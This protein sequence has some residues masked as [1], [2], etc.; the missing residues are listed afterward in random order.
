[1]ITSPYNFVPLSDKV[2]SPYWA[3]LVS[4]DIPFKDSESGVLDLTL[5]AESPIYVRNGVPKNVSDGEKNAF[6]NIDNNYFIPGSSIKGLLR[7]VMEIM[8][9]G[10]MGNKVNDHKYSVRDFQNNTIYPKSDLAKESLCGWL[11]KKDGKY[12]LE[13]CGKPGR[14]SH[15]ILDG[16]CRNGVLISEYY[17]RSENI[18]AQKKS[19]KSKYETFP[20]LKEG[21]DFDL[22]YTSV[23]RP[24]FKIVEKG[25]KGTIVFSGQASIR[26]EPEGQIP[27]GK[28]LEF[29]FFES[30]D[31]PFLLDESVIKNFF[32]A[33][34]D[35]EITQQKDDWKWRKPQLDKGDKIPVFFRENNDGS[36]KDM[37]LSLLYK[38]T[39]KNSIQDAINNQQK[40]SAALDLAETIFGYS[41]DKTSLKGRV[42]VGH[43]FA[44]NPVTPLSQI[45]EVLAGPK[46]SY[47]P[48]YIEQTNKNGI[49]NG[50]YSTFMNDK[51]NI[52]GWKR[53]PV[54]EGGI[55]TNAPHEIKGVVNANIGSTF[56]PLPPN[57]EFTFQIHYHNLRKEELGALISAIT[58]HNTEGL[59]HSL[60]SAK[61]LGYGK[62]TITITNLDEDKKIELLKLYEYYMDWALGNTTP[63]W[64][65]LPQIKELFS[66]AKP[67]ANDDQLKYMQLTD[68][69]N[70][71]GRRKTDPKFTL[72][73]YSVI[74]NNLVDIKALGT[75]NELNKASLN[76]D[77]EKALFEEQTN[78]EELKNGVIV[79]NETVFINAL[80]LKKKELLAKLNSRRDEI[81][82]MET[83][84]KEVQKK[85][86][87]HEKAASG[88]PS[89]WNDK[90]DFENLA[91][92]VPKWQNKLD[93]NIIS[94]VFKDDLASLIKEIITH[95][96]TVNKKKKDWAGSFEENKSYIKIAGWIDESRARILYEIFN[97]KN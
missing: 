20:F 87:S 65:Q 23:E 76:Y 70:A 79:K 49:L 58:F 92:R 16:L 14:I 53:Y 78:L 15:K 96:L 25:A 86:E 48:N 30:K 9:F 31:D 8:S 32:F 43:A 73:K 52:R 10:R 18:T 39:Y 50:D 36:I 6:N 91:K 4:H 71:K 66:M 27:S 60:G 61:P 28:H 59:F 24:V 46:A 62:S 29:V 1:M 88:L 44:K 69:V 12:Y 77:K 17:K 42:H 90:I 83:L 13:D 56:T 45:K 54:H 33:Y 82:E 21:Y 35:Q 74:A 11:F 7:S 37:G 3:N 67:G 93:K 80:D 85:L 84:E 75:K 41:D 22:E 34:Y 57:T 2:V 64:F 63:L 40:D 68:F 38:I 47:Y 81:I 5:K 89:E 55:K 19:A 95:E 26:K 72:Q 97:K 94:E 51:A